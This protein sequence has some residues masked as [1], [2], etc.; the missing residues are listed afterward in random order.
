MKKYLLILCS[1]SLFA[2]SGK[3]A[4]DDSMVIIRTEGLHLPPDYALLAPEKVKT[5]KKEEPSA[6]DKSKDLLLGA[7]KKNTHKKNNENSWLIK[8]AGGEKRIKN[9]K[10]ILEKDKLKEAQQKESK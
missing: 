2:C 9:I 4:P 10:K 1:I 3:K 7:E 6:T 5:I 8:K